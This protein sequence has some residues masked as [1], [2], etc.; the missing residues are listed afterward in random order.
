LRRRG[1]DETHLA[2]TSFARSL[3]DWWQVPYGG[4]KAAAARR[5]IGHQTLIHDVLARYVKRTRAA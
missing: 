4:S 5:D 2:L 1:E 3:H